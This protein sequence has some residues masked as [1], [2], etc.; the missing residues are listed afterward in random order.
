MVQDL[1]NISIADPAAGTRVFGDHHGIHLTMVN[2]TLHSRGHHFDL[3][4]P[5]RGPPEVQFFP[6]QLLSMSLTA[7]DCSSQLQ[8][9]ACALRTMEMSSHFDMEQTLRGPFSVGFRIWCGSAL[10]A[11]K[12]ASP[13][14]D[15]SRLPL[16]PRILWNL[17]GCAGRFRGRFHVP[18]VPK[19][20]H[21]S[22]LVLDN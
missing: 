20:L 10:M 18:S 15:M 12:E 7:D 5:E 2:Y 13:Q 8:S 19:L 11:G 6:K 3:L 1:M 22:M 17:W 4:L 14:K 16:L 21:D 9:C